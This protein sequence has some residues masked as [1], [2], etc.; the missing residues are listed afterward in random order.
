M[1][2][3]VKDYLQIAL[4]II[5]LLVLGYAGWRFLHKPT[6]TLAQKHE[7]LKKRVDE[8][9]DKFKIID[10]KF[11][12]VQD[13]L[14]QGNDKFREQAEDNTVFRECM[15]AFIDFEIA[16]CIHTGYEHNEDLIKAKSTLE[17]HLAK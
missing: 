7:E 10:A 14:N 1:A 5:N 13:S 8:H 17:K 3:Q 12:D 15:L 6:D 9:D 4:Q 2:S 16:Y 11:E